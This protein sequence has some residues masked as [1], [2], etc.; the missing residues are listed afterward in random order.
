MT[1]AAGV[2]FDLDGTLLELPVDIEPVRCAVEA[3]LAAAGERGA[4]RPVLDAIDRA[5]VAVAARHG[6]DAGRELW[7]EARRLIDEAE[8]AAARSARA[9][10]G[11]VEVVTAIVGIGDGIGIGMGNGIGIGVGIGI[12][13]D[14]GRACLAPA[15]EAAGLARFPWHVVTRD[16]VVRPKP[17]PDGI[18]A[19]ARALCPAGGAIWYVGDSPRDVVA[20]RAAAAEL[21]PD[22]RFH[23]VAVLGGQVAKAALVDA[24]PDHVVADLWRFADLIGVE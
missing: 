19:A 15:L 23:V 6:S 1:R 5:T 13:T 16:D 24:G 22:F 7:M 12:V 3:L 18:E 17:A 2:L 9:R 4:A 14:N 20:A 10:P 8:V 21:G 11:A